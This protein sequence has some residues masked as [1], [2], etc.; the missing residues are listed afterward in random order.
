MLGCSSLDVRLG[1]YPVQTLRK[2]VRIGA[3]AWQAELQAAL[4]PPA[5]VSRPAAQHLLTAC[6]AQGSRPRTKQTDFPGQRRRFTRR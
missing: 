4:V 6:A 1:H 5:F 3:D 2:Q